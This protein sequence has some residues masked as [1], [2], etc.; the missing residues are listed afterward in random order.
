MRTHKEAGRFKRARCGFGNA[1]QISYNTIVHR[2]NTELDAEKKGNVVPK[3]RRAIY[4]Y[5]V[6]PE[7]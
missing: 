1:P 4:E 6:L 7:E 3:G 2:N 5:K